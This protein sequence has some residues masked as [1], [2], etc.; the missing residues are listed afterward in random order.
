MLGQIRTRFSTCSSALD[1]WRIESDVPNIRQHTASMDAAR[2]AREK[3]VEEEKKTA[4]E[5]CERKGTQETTDV[6]SMNICPSKCQNA[7][8]AIVLLL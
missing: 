5:V 8:S 4:K 7:L 3:F 1:K 6:K 2:L